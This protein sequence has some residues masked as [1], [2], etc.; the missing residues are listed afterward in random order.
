MQKCKKS[1]LITLFCGV[2]ITI[3]G[4]IFCFISG[5]SALNS[6]LWNGAS[7]GVFPD[8]FESVRDAYNKSPYDGKSIYPAFAYLVC[9][10]ISRVAPGNIYDWASFSMSA[11]GI[12]V[13]F[14]FF[15]ICSAAIFLLTQKYIGD[16]IEHKLLL[17]LFFTSPGY[18]YCIER[19]NMVLLS[20]VFIIVFITGYESE[21]KIIREI[22]LISLA[23]AACLKIYP[24][25][26]GLLLLK[27][28]KIKDA[29]KCVIYGLLVFVLPFLSMGGLSK[30][31]VMISNI[32]SL[33][34]E[35]VYDT[36]NFGFGYKINVSNMSN[37]FFEWLNV[38]SNIYLQISERLNILLVVVVLLIFLFS[39]KKWEKIWA[40][41][42]ILTLLP[43]FS[44]IYNAIYFL[45]PFIV[46]IKE[47]NDF[48]KWTIITNVG[49]ILIL[50]ILPYGYIA[51]SL[52]GVNKL[53]ISTIVVFMGAVIITLSIFIRILTE[54]E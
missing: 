15:F 3:V 43:G 45:V 22:A 42:L 25:L 52:T 12:I 17:F 36:R 11:N 10:L 49:M 23:F 28:D 50:A 41:T 35:T 1:L 7:V 4:I 26:F 21:N 24:V 8:L 6:L 20:L 18:L 37:A 38:P 51:G 54:S 30:I 44:W 5:S 47:E 2:G 9:Y 31:P 13:G 34:M 39:K 46:Y 19:G 14:M 48:S 53:S 27:K 33:S 16:N 32:I 29:I 40:I